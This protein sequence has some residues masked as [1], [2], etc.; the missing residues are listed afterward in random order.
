MTMGAVESLR[1][2][3]VPRNTTHQALVTGACVA[4][5]GLVASPAGRVRLPGP[6]WLAP[7]L[8]A[9]AA[10]RS[11]GHV[12]AQRRSFPDWDPR[13]QRTGTALAVGT[14]T[15]W[16][17]A[18]TPRASARATLW[19][20]ELLAARRGGSAAGWSA[21]VATAAGAGVA[22]LAAVRLRRAFAGLRA[23]GVRADAPLVTAPGSPYVSGGPESLVDYDTLARDGRRFVSFRTPAEQIR[24]VAGRAMEPIRVYVGVQ[25]AATVE[26]RVDLAMAE[27]ERLGGLDR[28]NLLIVSP[29]GSGYI[30]YVAAE[31]FECFTGGDC[32]TVAIQYGVLPSIWSLG[33]VPLGARTVR[34]LLDRVTERVSRLE[35]RPRVFMY[36]ESLGAQVA[37]AALTST[38]SLVDAS[39]RVDGLDAVVSVGTPG[40]RSLRNDLLHSPGAVHVDRWQQL[41]GDGRAGL[42]FLDHDADPVARWDM[43][44]AWRPPAWLRSGGRNI[45][46]DMAWLPV[47]TWWQVVFDL[48]FAAQQASG[49]FQSIGHDYRA[50]LPHVLAAALGREVDVDLVTALLAQREMTRDSVL[51]MTTAGS[52]PY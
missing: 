22:G 36:G 10:A 23:T 11:A 7:V 15:G 4:T 33:R 47:L 50:D 51:E 17:V 43:T 38:P 27:L 3:L 20:G 1:P 18:R 49:M 35:R 21:A 14:L 48:A 52:L 39:A 19:A 41:T 24:Q 40:G 9:A 42:W 26:Q 45:P 44:L 2:T 13:P 8:L 25:S 12:R 34:S 6:R 32:A 46:E 29:A 5:M 28:S 37:Q 16:A 31:A 30:D